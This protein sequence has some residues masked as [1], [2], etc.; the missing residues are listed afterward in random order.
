[1]LDQI[2][3]EEK[4]EDGKITEP[5]QETEHIVNVDFIDIDIDIDINTPSQKQTIGD[6]SK[7][8]IPNNSETMSAESTS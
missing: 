1:M 5:H 3:L 4:K 2:I 6:P 8:W 7:A